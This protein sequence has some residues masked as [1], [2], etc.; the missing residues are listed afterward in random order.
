M[1]L[2]SSFLNLK[3][4]PIQTPDLSL[5]KTSSASQKQPKTLF[6]AHQYLPFI[7]GIISH[8]LLWNLYR[9]AIPLTWNQRK[10]VSWRWQDR[11]VQIGPKTLGSKTYE[12]EWAPWSLGHVWWN[13]ILDENPGCAVQKTKTKSVPEMK[14][15]CTSRSL[16]PLVDRQ[17]IQWTYKII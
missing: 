17:R 2:I 5:K 7:W 14:T 4:W 12:T 10:L 8:L 15:C 6:T 11:Y 16:M 9:P 1:D 13:I 3:N